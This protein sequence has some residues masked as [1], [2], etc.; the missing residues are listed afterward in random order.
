M[1][2]M[3]CNTTSTLTTSKAMAT[4]DRTSTNTLQGD[5]VNEAGRGTSTHVGDAAAKRQMPQTLMQT[6]P[7]TNSKRSMESACSS[8][9][10]TSVTSNSSKCDN[11]K[12]KTRK[13]KEPT[14]N[15]LKLRA[16]CDAGSKWELDLEEVHGLTD[17][18]ACVVVS[19]MAPHL[20]KDVFPPSNGDYLMKHAEEGWKLLKETRRLMALYPDCGDQTCINGEWEM[21]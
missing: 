2:T 15:H 1:P 6:L 8:D 9:S 12:K 21:L 7:Q 16:A 13:S 4:T 11:S 20:K 10:S 19:L 17:E 5:C 3:S 18:Q 14:E